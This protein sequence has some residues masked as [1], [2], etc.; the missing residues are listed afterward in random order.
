MPAEAPLKKPMGHWVQLLLPAV[1]LNEPA[2]QL[3]QLL[4]PGLE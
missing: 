4:L 3:V 1:A 2:E